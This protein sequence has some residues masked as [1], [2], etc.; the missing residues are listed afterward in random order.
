MFT[1][2]EDPFSFNHSHLYSMKQTTTPHGVTFY[3]QPSQY[4]RRFSTPYKRQQLNEQVESDVI[5]T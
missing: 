4:A 2:E 3:V 1:N 5:Y